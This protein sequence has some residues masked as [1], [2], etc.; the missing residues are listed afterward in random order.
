MKHTDIKTDLHDLIDKT[1]DVQIL[2]AIKV[3]LR[4]KMDEPD[5]WDTLPKHQKESIERGLAQAKRGETKSHEEAIKTD[6]NPYF[7]TTCKQYFENERKR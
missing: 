7:C 3:L 6:K 1:N 5:F 2:E 4:K